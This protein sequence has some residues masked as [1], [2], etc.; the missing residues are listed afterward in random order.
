[1]ASERNSVETKTC[2]AWNES[3]NEVCGDAIADTDVMCRSHQREF[4][5]Q[6]DERAWAE[7]DPN[8]MPLVSYPSLI[9]EEEHLR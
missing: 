6:K 8:W 7:D 5:R 1:M 2:P 4:N 9:D 3:R